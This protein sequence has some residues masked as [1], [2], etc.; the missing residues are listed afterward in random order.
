MK[1]I[2]LLLIFTIGLHTTKAECGMEGMQFYPQKRNISLNTI[3]LIEGYSMSQK[4]INSFKSRTVFLESEDGKLIKLNLIDIFKGKMDITQAIFKP[5]EELKSNTI[6]KLKYSDQTDDETREMMQ[7]NSNTKQTERVYWKT[8]DQKNTQSLIPNLNIKYQKT[9]VI[10]YGCG[11][12][13]NAIF[14]IKNSSDSEIWYKTEMI[15]LTTKEKTI[16]FITEWKGQIEV[17]HGMCSGGFTFNKRGKY[18]VRFTPMDTDGNSLK[19]TE[20][21]IFESPY[22]KYYQGRL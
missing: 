12:S 14:T 20:W 10:E 4:T 13:A 8:T 22:L 17:G 11:P 5:T 1:K 3:F 7:W 21:K 2:I 6:Y 19:S 15:D 18:K 9:E 16:F